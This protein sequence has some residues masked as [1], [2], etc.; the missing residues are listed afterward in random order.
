MAKVK[1]SSRDKYHAAAGIL[2]TIEASPI[3]LEEEVISAVLSVIH[4][5][6]GARDCVIIIK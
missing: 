3:A 1:S 5:F 6:G 2:K 4:V